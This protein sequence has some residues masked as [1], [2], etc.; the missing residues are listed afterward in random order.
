MMEGKL[1]FCSDSILRFRSDYDEM[2]ALPLLSIQKAISDTDPFFLLRLFRH[3]VM[4][5][6]GTKSDANVRSYAPVR[7]LL[8]TEPYRRIR[9]TSGYAGGYLL[10]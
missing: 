2:T 3:T 6:E 9:K 1:I 5:E 7:A 10:L 4:N 8:V